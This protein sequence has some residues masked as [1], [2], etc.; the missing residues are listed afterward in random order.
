MQST[1]REIIELGPFI[2]L[3]GASMSEV[4]ERLR[5]ELAELSV[6]ERAEL[7][8]YL[9]HSLDEETEEATG[10]AW[11]AELDRRWHEIE[12]GTA[13]G[14]PAE[15]VLADLREKYA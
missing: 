2:G 9:I 3:A 8:H 12:S 10:P 14:E 4:A 7:A 11:E 6:T 5:L 15:K 1:R 13:V